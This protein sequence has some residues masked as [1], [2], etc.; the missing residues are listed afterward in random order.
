MYSHIQIN[1]VRVNDLKV[2]NPRPAQDKKKKKVKNYIH[3]RKIKVCKL[4]HK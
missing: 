3:S 1:D 2:L 4:L